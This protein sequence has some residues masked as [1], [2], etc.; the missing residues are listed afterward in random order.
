MILQACVNGPR[1][2]R[3]FP[4]LPVSPAEIAEAAREAVAAGAVDLHVH[5]KDASGADTLA[6]AVVAEVV[7]RVR[8]AVPGVPVGVTTGAWAAPDPRERA[9]SVRSWT[10]L[11]DHAS[12]NWHEDGADLVAA[13]LAERGVGIEAGLFSGTD[14]VARFA[15]S[16]FAGKVLRVLAEVMD[17]GAAAAEITARALLS[18][19]GAAGGVPVLLHGQDGGAWPVLRLSVREGLSAR[20][21]LEDV[22]CLP[23]GAPAAGNGELVRAAGE[24]QAAGG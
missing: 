20:I 5:P 12:V 18:D 16:P 3:E 24:L 23:D 11:P 2:K 15:S 21:G 1:N 22:L 7:E 13:A 10:V 4:S 19:I 9:E 14:A 8:A 6:P 17:T